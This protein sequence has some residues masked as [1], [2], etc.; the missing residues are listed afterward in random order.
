MMAATFYLLV[1]NRPGL[2]KV[3]TFAVFLVADIAEEV[4]WS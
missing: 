3:A 1:R 4:S 2:G